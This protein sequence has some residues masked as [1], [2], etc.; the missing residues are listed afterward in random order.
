MKIVFVTGKGGVGKTSFSSSLALTKASEGHKVLLV[1]FGP[2][3]FL[4]YIFSKNK[5]DKKIIPPANLEIVT[6][7]Y[8]EVL[9]EFIAYFLKVKTLVEKFFSSPIMKKL[10]KVAPSLR[11]LVYLG[12]A[13]SPYRNIGKKMDYDY[14]IIDSYATGHFLS[15][16]RS[17]AGMMSAIKK[18]AMHEQCK[19]ILEVMKD[20]EK[21]SYYVV[22]LPEK[23][24]MIETKEFIGSLQDEFNISPQIVLNKIKQP[25][26]KN[27]K[28]AFEQEYSEQIG[29]QDNYAS[30]MNIYK[31]F[32]YFYDLKLSDLVTSMTKKLGD[33]ELV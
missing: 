10:I 17:P 15:L 24:P 18:G 3:P 13:T 33:N 7:N 14:L 19:T 20:P 2:K 6:W 32:P 23:L 8:E 27:G 5:V 25:L 9:I 28:T 21:V 22:T 1:E 4:N 11:E 31:S 12:K 30:K 16:L 26:R 29:H